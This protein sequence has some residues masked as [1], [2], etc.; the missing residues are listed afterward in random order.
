[1][2]S[3]PV[4]ARLTEE[5]VTVRGDSF[6]RKTPPAPPAAREPHSPSPR[7][8]GRF[9]YVS[10][11]PWGGGRRLARL[12]VTGPLM[13]PGLSIPPFFLRRVCK[14]MRMCEKKRFTG[15]TGR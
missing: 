5:L 1:M 2:K 9:L 12:D 10:I 8:A 13:A 7:R 15:S 11:P 4:V 6:A 3:V 14:E